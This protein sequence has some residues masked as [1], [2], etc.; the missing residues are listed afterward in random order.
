[1]LFGLEDA[2]SKIKEM[3]TFKDK[4]DTKIH[5]SWSEN[6][7]IPIYFL[8]YPKNTPVRTMWIKYLQNDTTIIYIWVNGHPTDGRLQCGSEQYR[9][10]HFSENQRQKHDVAGAHQQNG[11]LWV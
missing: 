6:K 10:D 1:M 7:L 4:Y 2:P 11:D 8:S 9:Q 5:Y 3:K